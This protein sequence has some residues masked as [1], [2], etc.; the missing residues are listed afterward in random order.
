M[1][2]PQSVL[3]KI[4]PKYPLGIP[5]GTVIKRAEGQIV[6]GKAKITLYC[7]D[8]IIVR[9]ESSAILDCNV[10]RP[11]PDWYEP[12]MQGFSYYGE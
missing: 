10:T 12:G 11:L 9:I 6:G 5:P 4:T 1:N 7:S 8:E 3:D 2:V